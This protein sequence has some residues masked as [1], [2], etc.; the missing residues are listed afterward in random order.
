[1]AIRHGRA[2][3]PLTLCILLAQIAVAQTAAA[4]KITVHVDPAQTQIRW[5]VRED[6]R[7]VRGTFAL[8]G[9]ILVF[10]PATGAANGE[11]LVDLDTGTSGDAKRDQMMKTQVLDSATYPEAIFHPEKVQGTL[12]P[13]GSSRLVVNG[14]FTLHGKDHPLQVILQAQMNGATEIQA[15]AQF[16]VPYVNWGMKDPSTATQHF[17]HEVRVSVTAKGS[18]EGLQ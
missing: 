8:K 10:D 5:T 18:V 6:L 12:Q 17:A 11:M 16:V 7:T 14:T 1:M 13:G 9:G 2:L 4:K 15:S 3:L